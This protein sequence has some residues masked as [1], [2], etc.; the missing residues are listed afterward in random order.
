MID[1]RINNKG[2]A[3]ARNGNNGVP[4]F[5]FVIFENEKSAANCLSQRPIYLPD[6]HR[7]NV[8]TKK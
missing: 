8:E 1:V 5:A 6:G 2:I 7:L 4:N 3:H